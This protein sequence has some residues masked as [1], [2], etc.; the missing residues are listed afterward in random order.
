L[1]TINLGLLVI[2]VVV[3]YNLAIYNS[4]TSM[5]QLLIKRVIKFLEDKGFLVKLASTDSAI[6]IT[7]YTDPKETYEKFQ[8]LL[9]EL[10]DVVLPE[11][12]QR[13]FNP[14][15]NYIKI[16][17]EK[18]FTRCIFVNK[19]YYELYVAVYEDGGRVVFDDKPYAYIKGMA[20]VRGS[21]S[22]ITQRVQKKFVDMY[23]EKIPIED[24]KSYLT[25]E[26]DHFEDNN[27]EDICTHGN[28]SMGINE[29]SGQNYDGARNS[30]RLFDWN[31]KAGDKPLVAKFTTHPTTYND[32]FI[33]AKDMSLSFFPKDADFLQLEGFDL[34]YEHV[35]K[36]TLL[37]PLD[38]LII[39]W[40][41]KTYEQFIRVDT[42]DPYEE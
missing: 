33:G 29:G 41:G 31:L 27:W 4:P 6:A 18:V 14:I 26:Y 42:N 2:K 13:E 25:Y 38:D 21:S 22:N 40:I 15:H 20:Y 5:G 17:C 24:I 7:R 8:E 37:N 19:R 9:I 12:I 1:L 34:D 39:A 3:G 11:Y 28:I 35:R 16:G 23:N 36:I 32:R 10:N 30:N